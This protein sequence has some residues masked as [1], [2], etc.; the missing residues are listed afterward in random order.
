MCLHNDCKIEPSIHEE[1]ESIK[2]D[3]RYRHN[4]HKVW[5]YELFM[6]YFIYLMPKLSETYLNGKKLG[7]T[8]MAHSYISIGYIRSEY[9]DFIH[10]EPYTYYVL[11]ARIFE[12]AILLN[13][14]KQNDTILTRE[15]FLILANRLNNKF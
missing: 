10:G 1:L 3:D 2:T 5:D 8:F 7:P 6:T 14:L 15:W 4:K 13:E 12:R 9:W 11:L